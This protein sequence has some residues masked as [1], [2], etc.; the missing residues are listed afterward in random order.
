MNGQAAWL[1]LRLLALHGHSAQI[2]SRQIHVYPL[3]FP[4]KP[5]E[6]PGNKQERALLAGL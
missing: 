1:R 3:R 6:S 5:A 4:K 2:H